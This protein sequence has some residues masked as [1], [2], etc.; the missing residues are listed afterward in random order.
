[1][2]GTLVIAVTAIM[3]SG[4]THLQLRRSTLKQQRTLADL[5]CQQV[6][7]NVAQFVANPDSMPFFSYAATGS[8]QISDAGSA[9][10][11]LTWDPRTL[12]SEMLGIT[13]SRTVVEGWGLS[14]IND[15]DRL[16]AMRCVYRM[17]VGAATSDCDDCV[18]RLGAFFNNDFSKQAH[19]L[20]P[21]GWFQV[22]CKADVPRCACYVSHACGRYVWVTPEGLD[23]LTRLTLTILDIATVSPYHAPQR[24]IVTTY[25]ADGKP[26]TTEIT[27]TQ[28]IAPPGA[29][30]MANT[31]RLQP[32][33]SPSQLRS[34]LRP[35]EFLVPSP[36]PIFFPQPARR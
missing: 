11:N 35:R 21:M 14:A 29:S 20:I 9:T 16:Y 30:P 24:T 32:T 18:S 12:V 22:G 3:V 8:T 36:G 23:G 34:F 27:E 28:D 4:C 7:D 2:R 5:N 6:L 25:G 13:G 1:M 15:P 26:L 33:A 10:V 17:V 31:E 19:C